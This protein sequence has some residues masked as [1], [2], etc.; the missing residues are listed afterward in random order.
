VN[1]PEG[2]TGTFEL[3]WETRAAP[4]TGWLV[5]ARRAIVTRIAELERRSVEVWTLGPV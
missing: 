4:G 2:L 5:E 3:S 1:L